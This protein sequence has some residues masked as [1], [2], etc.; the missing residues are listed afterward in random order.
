MPAASPA[1]IVMPTTVN[2]KRQTDI[3]DSLLQDMLAEDERRLAVLMRTYNPITGKD[4]PGMRFEFLLSDFLDGRTLYMPVEMLAE[5]FIKVLINCG[6]FDLYIN[7]YLPDDGDYNQQREAVMRH[8]IWLRCKHDFLFFAGAFAKIKNKDGGPDINFKL[9]PA[10]LKLLAVLEDMRKKRLPIR[11]ILLKCR[12]WG[13]STLTDIYMGWIQIFWK[14]NWNSNIVGHQSTSASNV[15]AMYEK[16]I[17]NVPDWLFFGLGEEYP[18]DL[19][20]FSGVGTTQNIKRMNPRQCNI[21]TGSA[22][23]PDSARST[24]A[25]MIHLTEEAFFPETQEWTPQKV[26]TSVISSVSK[27]AP[28]SFIVRESTPNGKNSFYDAW[29]D[30][31]KVDPKTGRKL[32]AYTGVFVAW[33]E[34]EKY[35]IPMTEDERADFIIEL[36]RN[37]NDKQNHGDYF[38]WLWTKG[39]TVEGIKW[40]QTALGEMTSL[41]DMQQEYPSD[42]IEAFRFSGNI[43]FD[44]YRVDELEKDCDIPIFEGDIE[45]DSL[46]PENIACMD[47][48]RL[49]ERAGGPLRIWELPDDTEVVVNRYLAAV[50]IGGAHKTSDFHDIVVFDRYDLMYGGVEKVVAEWH[51]HCDPDQLAMRC[52]Q[53]A[54]FYNDA[55]LVVENNTA[56]SK[57]NNTEGDVSQLLFP[58]LLPLYD[59]LYSGNTS[60]LLKHRQKE[61]KWGINTN[62]ST[63]PAFI[64]HYV[65]VVR[66]HA[67]IESEKEAL[68]EMGYYLFFPEK[69]QYGAAPGYHDDRV[70][71]RAIGLFVSKLDMDAPYI[72]YQKSFEELRQ[73]RIRAMQER[74]PVEVGA[75]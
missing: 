23:N 50:D 40:Y 32:S 45:G 71:A 34:I 64:K 54:H 67:Y 69:G 6:S 70:M 13:G 57:M 12:Q 16:L 10:Q 66:Q 42:D 46:L 47:N 8:F 41:E 48:I 22:R 63:K 43:V 62:V 74:P 7:R 33:F 72:E 35:L 37:R 75:L 38:W 53:I 51:G 2:I 30:T 52:A 21:Q 1:G 39:A 26:V 28:L 29:Q 15:F 5:P 58:I 19:K 9:R 59:N 4:A 56:Y 55:Y 73:E 68:V 60:K 36:W 11:V 25:A 17:T 3:P 18:A 14:T 49:V 24:D 20:K 44:S 27:T 61:T 31:K 65:K